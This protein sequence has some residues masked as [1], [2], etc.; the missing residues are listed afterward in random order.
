MPKQCAAGL[1]S[2]SLGVM[3]GIAGG[4]FA[5]LITNS[6]NQY[7][8]IGSNEVFFST[9]QRAASTRLVLGGLSAIAIGYTC[10]YLGLGLDY[11]H[12]SNRKRNERKRYLGD[13]NVLTDIRKV[14][15]KKSNDITSE[16]EPNK[17]PPRFNMKPTGS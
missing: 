3:G 14:L 15:D 13:R 6:I 1:L 4:Y 16:P 2:F 5:P 7:V 17:K 9:E 12:E 11:L 8:P 10:Y